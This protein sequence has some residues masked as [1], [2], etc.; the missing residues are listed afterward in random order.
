MTKK[1]SQTDAVL[2]MISTGKATMDECLKHSDKKM[3]EVVRREWFTTT[4]AT[5]DAAKREIERLAAL[6]AA[7][8]DETRER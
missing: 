8:S 6:T 1:M 5:L 3:R 4:A 2:Y 7:A